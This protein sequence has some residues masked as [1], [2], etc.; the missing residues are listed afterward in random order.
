[1]IEL[2]EGQ[3]FAKHLIASVTALDVENS[4]TGDG[5]YAAGT[6]VGISANTPPAGQEFDVWTGATS[7]IANVNSASTTFTMGASNATVTATYRPVTGTQSPYGGTAIAIP[8]RIQ[9]EDYDLGGE[10][11]AYH[12]TDTASTLGRIRCLVLAKCRIG[13]QP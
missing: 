13:F 10:G 2:E 7:G 4:G 1:M 8:G 5:S 12:D 6:A 9:A 3:W 11:V